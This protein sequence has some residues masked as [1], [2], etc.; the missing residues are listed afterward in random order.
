MKQDEYN[1]PKP[2]CF[3]D[4][5]LRGEPYVRSIDPRPTAV[6]ASAVLRDGKLWTGHRHWNIIS[7]VYQDTGS[8]DQVLGSEQGFIADTGLFLTRPQAIG[9]AYDNDQ[10]QDGW[11]KGTLTS[12]DLW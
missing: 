1:P 4:P 3:N 8:C 6:V 10:L 11:N 2:E 9:V 7:M 12:E 5:C